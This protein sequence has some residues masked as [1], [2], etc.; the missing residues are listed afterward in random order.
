[1][2]TFVNKYVVQLY[3]RNIPIDYE[4]KLRLEW[5]NGK[6]NWL[7]FP[8][9]HLTT[10]EL[11]VEPNSLPSSKKV[12]IDS[13]AEHGDSEIAGKNVKIKYDPNSN[14]VANFFILADSE[15]RK[16]L[17]ATFQGFT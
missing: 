2:A 10:L 16:F 15:H 9:S 3:R 4:I 17:Q 14:L 6:T 13:K 12:W 7:Y 5:T 8:N 1:M 11:P